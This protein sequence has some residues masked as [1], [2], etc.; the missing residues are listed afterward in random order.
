MNDTAIYFSDYFNLNKSQMEL[1]FVNVPINRDIPLFIDPFALSQRVDRW[2]INAHQTLKSYFQLILDRIIDGKRQEALRLL[3]YLKEPN[4]TRF[5][6]SSRRPKG[7]GIGSYQALDLFKALASSSAI[8]SGV[9]QSLEECELMIEGINRDK[10]SDLTTNVIRKI[11]AEYTLEQC[12]LHGIN[13][14]HVPLPPYFSPDQ[15]SW[16]SSYYQLPVAFTQPVLLVPKI[17]ARYEPAYNHDKYYRKFILEFLQAE[18]LSAMSSLVRTLKNGKNVVY[19]KDLQAIFPKTKEYI[20]EFTKEHPNLLNEYRDYLASLELEKY[21]QPLSDEDQSHIA[22]ILITS[23]SNIAPGPENATDY[24]NLMI[25]ILEFIFFPNLIHPIKEREINQGR[26][27]IDILMENG[28]NTGLFYALPNIRQIP[29]AFI[30]FECK[31]YSNDVANPELDQLL[32]RFSTN[33]GRVG[34]ICCRKLDDPELFTNRC[35]DT[36][37]DQNGLIVYLDDLRIK[38][39]LGELKNRHRRNVETLLNGY[40][41]DVILG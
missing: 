24:H 39:L 33:R 36:L 25:G 1:D 19:K 30:A 5:G 13:T 40:F 31:N 4:E 9:I 37:K 2:S 20:F 11:L 12:D 17:I 15:N 26:K 28:A 41:N 34:F 16:V 35:I 21:D 8:K 3:L 32:G 14:R 18:H 10:I 29:S 23:L 6:Y 7:A 27:R 22:D 38:S